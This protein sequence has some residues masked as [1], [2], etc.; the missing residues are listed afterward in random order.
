MAT[1]T[2]ADFVLSRDELITEAFRKLEIS[3]N[4]TLL[5]RGAKVLNL[6]IRQE[7]E[8]GPQQAKHLWAL[9][10]SALILTANGVI[11]GT[12]QGL[13]SNI[14]E[15]SSVMYRNTSGD[16][17][18]VTILDSPQYEAKSDKNTTGDVSDVYLKR[19]DVSRSNQVLYVYPTPSSVGTT[20]EV[21]G[22]DSLNYS[23]IMGHTSTTANKPITG[24]NWKLYWRQ[25]GTAGVA[26]VTATA[27]TNGELL[28]YVYKRP[29]FD[30]DLSTD[31]PDMPAAWTRYLIWRLANDLSP[32][33]DLDME[34]RQWL[35]GEYR[36]AAEELFGSTRAVTTDLHNK[37]MYY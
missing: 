26:W 37:A 29:L 21:I 23:C 12:S 1:G 31:N 5:T 9:S 3:A 11:Y 17:V 32:E 20:S 25:T 14:I 6:I 28:R 18:P 34:S 7:D 36:E 30:F 22:S 15:L 16:D 10:E 27:Y 13:E 24:Q 4:S 33:F 2:T 8:K 19:D 35:K